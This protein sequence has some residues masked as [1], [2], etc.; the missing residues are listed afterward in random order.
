[1]RSG[2]GLAV[3]LVAAS[4]SMKR[5]TMV[6]RMPA[7]IPHSLA[8]LRGNELVQALAW[9]VKSGLASVLSAVGCAKVVAHSA[10][11]SINQ[12][13]QNCLDVEGLPL[14]VAHGSGQKGNA[15]GE[16]VGSAETAIAAGNRMT[17]FGPE[18][19][20]LS[21]HIHMQPEYTEGSAV[22]EK[23]PECIEELG[24]D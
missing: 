15:E 16:L 6:G 21:P 5:I 9:R 11:A 10:T 14:D 3:S 17:E 12:A 8:T 13:E 1:M 19:E 7:A 18:L 23:Q 22:A 24:V 20:V 2:S 4:G